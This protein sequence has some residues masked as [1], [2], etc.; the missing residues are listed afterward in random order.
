MLNLIVFFPYKNV[1]DEDAADNED[2]GGN[3]QEI[4]GDNWGKKSGKNSADNT[5]KY[6]STPKKANQSL[7]FSGIKHIVD[8]NPKLSDQNNNEHI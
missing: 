3:I 6:A 5:S 1:I 8:D 4:I 7:G 2:S